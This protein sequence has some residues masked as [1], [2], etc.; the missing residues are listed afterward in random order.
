MSR[1]QLQR[2]ALIF[3]LCAAII[4]GAQSLEATMLMPSM[5]AAVANWD[6]R[7]QN[8]RAHIPMEH[9]LVGY[10]TDVEV[11]GSVRNPDDASGERVLT[12]FAIAPLIIVSG[13][14]QE[15]NILNLSPGAYQV[16]RE[17]NGERFIIVASGGN[18][19]LTRKAAR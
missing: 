19:Y 16:W 10:F 7:V 1:T 2:L 12:Q 18:L 13:K 8:L 9:G 4:T 6:Q 14:E 15:W 3:M 11:V 5:D 17:R